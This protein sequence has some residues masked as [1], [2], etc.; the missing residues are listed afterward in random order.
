MADKTYFDILD[1][2]ASDLVDGYDY[3]DPS[4]LGIDV[5]NNFTEEVDLYTRSKYDAYDIII[6]AGI[7]SW[8]DIVDDYG[9]ELDSIYG[10]AGYVLAK[11]FYNGG[12]YNG[13][14]ERIMDNR[15]WTEDTENI[16]Y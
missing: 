14:I 7:E 11:E 2:I 10:L 15:G 16:Y 13:I 8:G 12:Y 9:F 3:D 6:S 4:M 1:A 5:E